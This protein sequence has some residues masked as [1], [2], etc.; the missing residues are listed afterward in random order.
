ML[1][2]IWQPVTKKQMVFG[3]NN[4]ITVS[5]GCDVSSAAFNNFPSSYYHLILQ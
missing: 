4:S 2:E 3:Y 5:E 1:T